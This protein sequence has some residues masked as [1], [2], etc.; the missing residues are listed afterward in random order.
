MIYTIS[1]YIVNLLVRYFP[2]SFISQIF[3]VLKVADQELLLKAVV[4]VINTIY[5]KENHQA[6]KEIDSKNTSRCNCVAFL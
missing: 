6:A 4:L 1:I 2:Y 5:F 3:L